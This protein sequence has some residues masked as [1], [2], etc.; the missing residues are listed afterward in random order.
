MYWRTCL[1]KMPLDRISNNKRIAKNTLYM[2]FR[3]II[4]IIISLYMSRVVLDK[5][6]A[7]DYGIYGSVTSVVAMLLFLNGTL[8][9]GTSRF[10]TFELAT[11]NKRK[12]IETFNTTFYVHLLL[13]IIIVIMLE[14]IGL[15]FLNNRLMIPEDRMFASNVIF[16]FSIIS[17]FFSITQ[18]PYTSCIMAHE[19]MSIYA[20]ISI[21]DAILKLIIAFVVSISSADKLIVYGLLIGIEQIFISLT[22][23]YY[24]V[25][26]YEEGR[27]HLIFSKIIFIKLL[28]F[29]GWNLLAKLSQSFKIQGSTIIL[30]VFF[31][32]AIVAAHSIASQIAAQTMQLYNNFKVALDPQIVKLYAAGEQNKSRDL[33]LKSTIYVFDLCLLIGLPLYLLM[34]YILK[35]WLVDV[36]AYAVVFARLLIV[37]NILDS[38]QNM[39][40]SS[41]VASGKLK[42]NSLSGLLLE[43][44][45]ITLLYVIYN[46]GGDVLWVQY[47]YIGL[48]CV[49]SFVLRPLILIKEVQYN[50]RFIYRVIFRCIK[51]MFCSVLMVLPFVLLRGSSDWWNLII[52]L[53]SIFSVLIVS[54]L[55]LD[56]SDKIIVRDFVKRKISPNIIK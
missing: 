21:V 24:V 10:I 32:P 46:N 9:S 8:S 27:L 35:I 33:V 50:L 48:A 56:N 51:I 18:I 31:Q 16:Q 30:N 42:L 25:S 22:F 53:T 37:Q 6:G 55:F 26:H 39:F 14:T 7:D 13:A 2:Y 36:P 40:Y 1:L 23:R 54:Y 20:Y 5:L 49:Q 52:L 29:T 38:I 4:V 3:M 44:I 17:T 12:L 11:N 15:W 43:I 19:D 47:I 34:D 41:L 45:A 28:N